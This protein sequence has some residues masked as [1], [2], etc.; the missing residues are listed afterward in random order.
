MDRCYT[1]ELETMSVSKIK[2][3]QSERLIK[4][5]AHVYTNVPY[6]RKRMMEAGLQPVDIKTVDDLHKL[7]FTDK[8]DLRDT[9][10]VL[11]ENR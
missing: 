4:Q 1:P 7:P 11:Q 9:Y 2:G 8:K 6:Y 5:V 10:P 3:L